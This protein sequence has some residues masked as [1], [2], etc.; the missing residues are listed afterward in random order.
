MERFIRYIF[1]NSRYYKSVLK[2]FGYWNV[3]DELVEILAEEIREEID[4]EIIE[5]LSK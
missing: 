2:L 5:R 4:K 1:R 3:E